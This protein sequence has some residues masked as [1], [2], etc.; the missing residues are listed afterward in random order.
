MAK[1]PSISPRLGRF[2]R[3]ADPST[4]E[5]G[6]PTG[7]LGRRASL[8]LRRIGRSL[9]ASLDTGDDYM[10]D[11]PIGVF[12]DQHE[13][14]ADLDQQGLTAEP[15]LIDISASP[16]GIDTEGSAVPPPIAP[17]APRQA[18]DEL[19]PGSFAPLPAEFDLPGTAPPTDPQASME[20][21]TESFPPLPG[22]LDVPTAPD[23]IAPQTQSEP[24]APAPPP[25]GAELASQAPTGSQTTDV[26]TVDDELVGTT[27]TSD[28]QPLSIDADAS[29]PAFDADVSLPAIDADVPPPATDADA[30]TAAI[31]ADMPTAAGEPP[32]QDGPPPGAAEPPVS[33][34]FAPIPDIDSE[35]A[36]AG[37]ASSQEPPKTLTEEIQ[38]SSFDLDDLGGDPED[39]TSEEGSEDLGIG[40]SSDSLLDLFRAEDVEENPVADLAKGL[41]EVDIHHLVEKVSQL[42]TELKGELE[43]PTAEAEDPVTN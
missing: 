6:Q 43:E 11:D 35:A 24:Q 29:P 40:G 28:S 31:D 16:P 27:A 3:K 10:E 18:P 19:Q 38:P 12:L 1:K 41:P 36:D 25:P 7:P 2:G 22:D 8:T 32:Q 26:P 34:E 39:S 42:A 23:P 33:P 20:P 13:T 15:G 5:E 30:S 4:D 9:A 17:Q 21:Q 37:T 14:G